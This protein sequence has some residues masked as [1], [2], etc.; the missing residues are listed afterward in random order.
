[1][2]GKMEMRRWNE[3]ERRGIKEEER[4]KSGRECA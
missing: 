3:G 2:G 1:M 4:L